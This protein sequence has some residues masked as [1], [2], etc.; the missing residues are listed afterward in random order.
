MALVGPGGCGKSALAVRMLSRR[1]ISEY[2]PVLEDTYH[3]TINNGG[4]QIS[5]EVMDTSE[6]Q[7]ETFHDDGTVSSCV[8]AKVLSFYLPP[9]YNQQPS[10]E[11]PPGGLIGPT[12]CWWSTP[13]PTGPA[14]RPARPSSTSSSPPSPLSPLRPPH[15]PQSS[16]SAIRMTCRC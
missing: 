2:S 8:G 10:S 11:T 13:S 7:G 12:S 4:L 14:W 6:G 5:L 1:F 16:R 3:R 15:T 9:H